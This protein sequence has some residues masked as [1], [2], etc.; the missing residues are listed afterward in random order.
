MDRMRCLR[1]KTSIHAQKISQPLQGTRIKGLKSPSICRDGDARPSYHAWENESLKNFLKGKQIQCGRKSTYYCSLKTVNW[2]KGYRNV[3]PIAGCCGTFNKPAPLELSNFDFK[4]KD[5]RKKIKIKKLVVN[6]KHHCVG[7]DVGVGKGSIH[8]EWAGLFPYVDISLY[9]YNKETKAQKLQ[10]TIRYNKAVPRKKNQTVEVVFKKEFNLNPNTHNIMVKISY[11]GNGDGKYKTQATNPS[12]IYA[13]GLKMNLDY[14]FVDVPAIST[15]NTES[16]VITDKRN[17]NSS[18]G[19]NNCR[20]QTSHVITYANVDP[21]NIKVSYPKDIVLKRTQINNSKKTVTYTYEDISG[22]AGE[23]TVIYTLNTKPKQTIKKTITSKAPQKPNISIQDKYIKNQRFNQND[24]F[25]TISTG[26]WFNIKIKENQTVIYSVNSPN[27]P[28]QQEFLEAINALTCGSHDLDVYIDEAFIETVSIRILAP[29]IQF[30]TDMAAEYNQNKR[31]NASITIQRVDN[32]DIEPVTVKITDTAKQDVETHDFDVQDAITYE[33]DLHLPGSFEITL[34]YDNG[35][36]LQ[37]VP[38][39]KYVILPTHIQSYDNLLIRSETS[40]EYESIVV[41][42]GDNVDKPVTYVDASLISSMDDFTIFAKDGLCEVGDL[43]FG[44]VAVKNNLYNQSIQNLYIELN[45]IVYSEDV[46]ETF[47]SLPTEWKTGMLQNF[48]QNFYILNPLVKNTVEVLNIQNSDLINEGAENVIL[49]INEILPEQI[50][51]LK[52]PYAYSYEREI[53]MNFLIL[54]EPHDFIDLDLYSN[55]EYDHIDTSDS[56]QYASSTKLPERECLCIKLET[57]DMMSV[58]LYIEGDDLDRNDLSNENDLDI[59]YRIQASESECDELSAATLEFKTK[60][61][62]DARLIPT[63]YQIGKTGERI[64]FDFEDST[65]GLQEYTSP[66][67]YIS[68]RRGVE[69]RD[70]VLAG[71]D[72]FLRYID[73]NDQPRLIRAVTD[74]NGIATL[75]F[76]IPEY[77]ENDT[78]YLSSLLDNVDIFYKGNSIHADAYLDTKKTYIPNTTIDVLG[79]LIYYQDETGAELKKPSFILKD[80]INTIQ[81]DNISRVYLIG[82]LFNSHGDGLDGEIVKYT[83]ENLITQFAVTGNNLDDLCDF[84]SEDKKGMFRIRIKTEDDVYD[85]E[86]LL[87][88]GNIIYEGSDEAF[89]ASFQ[90]YDQIDKQQTR[91]EYIHDYSLYRKG[92]LVLIRVKLISEG[93]PHFVNTIELTQKGR[94]SH[95]IHIFYKPC[96]S[97]NTEGFKTIYQTNDDRLLYSQTEAMIYCGVDTDLKILGRLQKKIVENHEINILTIN[98]INGYK[99]NKNVLVKAL[100]GPNKENK[101]LGD[102]LSLTAVDIDKEKYSYD[103]SLD[104]IYWNIGDMKSY[105]TQKCNILLEA[106]NVGH[107]T[108]YLCGF[109]YLHEDSETTIE[110]ELSLDTSAFTDIEEEED[111]YIINDAYYVGDLINLKAVLNAVGTN[112][113]LYGKIYFYNNNLIHSQ[114]EISNVNNDYYAV[115]H[116]K[117]SPNMSLT[118]Q[119]DGAQILST[120]YLP[121]KTKSLIFNNIQ[122]YNITIDMINDNDEVITTSDNI[123]I[124]GELKYDNDKVY[125]DKDLNVKFFVEDTEIQNILYE[126]NQYVIRFSI[127]KPGEYHVKMFVPETDKTMASQGD[128]V[129]NI[130]DGDNN[131]G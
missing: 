89:K 124:R 53:F 100:V 103:K 123:V 71:K 35:C 41:R 10:E 50:I 70:M 74:N 51:E 23:K 106:E 73:Q 63:G 126:N 29:N 96:S 33:V 101:K 95:N 27:T 9:T 91:L 90:S 40:I 72:V 64:T 121:S 54:G 42:Q 49:K 104:I 80:N 3:C 13:T 36:Q 2:I 4:T 110:T 78:Y 24:S 117:L 58:D 52:I 99:P 22:T 88:K 43:G 19:V 59:T 20:T 107:N 77:Y 32:S 11:A 56:S 28:N 30:Q 122:K 85:F 34:E 105:E 46:S 38:L 98:A 115:T 66:D 112:Q 1:M 26:C 93:A 86:E 15:T 119:Y 118:A 109:D 108:I 55:I 65:P 102:Y 94:C 31:E 79:F 113:N 84:S 48:Y 17:P 16:I 12:I 75:K 6:Y 114:S 81:D 61:I 125:F 116:V 21:N 111:R 83:Y 25:I 87:L 131:D 69:K 57:Q 14:E 62:N 7:V 129:I 128:I 47:K 18:A 39:R 130:I 45:P 76:I 68:V 127:T 92:E 120:T 67:G 82:K 44:L 8:T 5:I 37:S 60:I 97:T